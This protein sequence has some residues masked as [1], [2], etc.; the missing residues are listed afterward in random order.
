[1]KAPS[2]S[3]LNTSNVISLGIPAWNQGAL[4]SSASSLRLFK[5]S[6]LSGKGGGVGVEP[7]VLPSAGTELLEVL[8]CDLLFDLN[9][10]SVP[11]LGELCPILLFSMLKF[12]AVMEALMVLS[13]VSE[14]CILL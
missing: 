5:L 9:S 3:W 10:V 8:I 13:M 12:L 1:M 2:G 7:W 14:G 4:R 6:V 11:E